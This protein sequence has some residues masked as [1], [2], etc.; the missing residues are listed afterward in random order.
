MPEE[1]EQ[2]D[3]TEKWTSGQATVAKALSVLLQQ[4]WLTPYNLVVSL[5]YCFCNLRIH[6]FFF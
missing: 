4:A 6:R 5:Y 2:N 1:S 3:S